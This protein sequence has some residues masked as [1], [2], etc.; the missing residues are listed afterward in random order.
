MRKVSYFNLVGVTSLEGLKQPAMSLAKSKKVMLEWKYDPP[1]FLEAPFRI[2]K[3]NYKVEISDGKIEAE[4]STTFFDSKK[5]AK[6]EIHEEINDLFLGAQTISFKPFK[7]FKPMIYRT[8]PDD[9]LNIT[10]FL[11]PVVSQ[12]VFSDNVDLIVKDKNGNIVKDTKAERIAAERHFA[13][14]A[15]THKKTDS[16]ARSILNSFNKAANDPS[17][18]FIY[19]FEIRDSLCKRFSN[20]KGLRDALGIPRN[21]LKRLRILANHEPLV[22]GRHRGKNPDQLRDATNEEKSEARDIARRLIHNYLEY[23]QHIAIERGG[24]K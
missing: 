22:Q 21:E 17:N 16:I 24:V 5:D 2:E 3:D 12:C 10:L 15:A 6:R 14:L 4:I 8:D 20:E 19:L 11:T 13:E 7:L 9:R 18:E 23:L 1:D